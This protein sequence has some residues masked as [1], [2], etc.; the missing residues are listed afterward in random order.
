M[1][2]SLKNEANRHPKL[3]MTPN[4]QKVSLSH[5]QMVLELPI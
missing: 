3:S 2:K 4:R 1:D 5:K